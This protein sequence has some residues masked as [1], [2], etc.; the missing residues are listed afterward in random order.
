VVDHRDTAVLYYPSRVALN[1]VL[2]FRISDYDLLRGL[3]LSLI[4]CPLMFANYHKHRL[5]SF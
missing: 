2:I 5:L 3:E 1:F 4:G